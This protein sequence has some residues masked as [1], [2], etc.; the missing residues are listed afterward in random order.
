VALG[1]IALMMILAYLAKKVVAYF[2]EN[3]L[4]KKIPGITLLSLG[5]Y[6][7]IQYFF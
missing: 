6:A 7:I 4:L 2:Q 1:G 3:K 5:L